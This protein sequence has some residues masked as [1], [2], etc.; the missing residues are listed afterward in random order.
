MAKAMKKTKL[1]YLALVLISMASLFMPSV[2]AFACCCKDFEMAHKED[3][4]HREAGHQTQAENPNTKSLVEYEPHDS[5]SDDCGCKCVHD[6]KMP[7][8]V[9]DV[10]N[11]VKKKAFQDIVI[12]G[13]EDVLQRIAPRIEKLLVIAADSSSYK[14]RP[15]KLSNPRAPPLM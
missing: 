4:C 3:P 1:K 7:F 5:V 15:G 8:S 2:S 14:Y 6:A 12:N 13:V 10:N 9:E 11:T